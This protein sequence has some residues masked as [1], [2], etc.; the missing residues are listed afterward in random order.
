[1]AVE[2]KALVLDHFGVGLTATSERTVWICELMANGDF[3]AVQEIWNTLALASGL[4]VR[5]SVAGFIGSPRDGR[6]FHNCALI[7]SV[8]EH[9]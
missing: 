1:M 5:W 9:P 8:L 4:L 2:S 7:A 3:D 6:F